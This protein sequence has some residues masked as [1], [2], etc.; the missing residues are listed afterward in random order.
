MRIVIAGAGAVGSHLAKMLANE[1]HDIVL[2]DKDEEKLRQMGAMYDLMTLHG[3]ATSFSL[4]KDTSIKKV[5]LFIAVT[6]S[7]E[8]NITAAVISKKLGARK[9]IARV[10]NH[11]YLVPSNK[12]VFTSLGI[13]YLI[14]PEMIAANEVV[15]LLHQTGTTDLVDF[16]G[17]KLSMYVLKL[18]ENAPIIN[19]S[20]QEVKKPAETLP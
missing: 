13:D 20:L 4:L 17:G 3:S 1:N 9:A 8:V 6:E 10:D 19:K 11:E 2:I 7:E 5:D 12:E 15:S 16:S 14:Y 18:E